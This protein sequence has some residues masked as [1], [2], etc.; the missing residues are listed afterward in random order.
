MWIKSCRMG[1][2]YGRLVARRRRAGGRVLSPPQMTGNGAFGVS[3]ET[4][5]GLLRSVQPRRRKQPGYVYFMRLSGAVRAARLQ[6]P[7]S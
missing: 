2:F 3:R 4:L 1:A 5:N 7:E 6:G